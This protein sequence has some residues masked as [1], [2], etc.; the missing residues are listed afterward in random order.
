MALFIPVIFV[1]CALIWG[2]AG[3]LVRYAEE[4]EQAEHVERL[5]QGV[6]G[7]YWL[8]CA[9]IIFTVLVY[10]LL[11]RWSL[12]Y[13]LLPAFEVLLLL[14]GLLAGVYSRLVRQRGPLVA[15]AVVVGL[16]SPVL[17][18]WLVWYHPATFYHTYPF[19]IRTVPHEYVD[20]RWSWEDEAMG[21]PTTGL[22]RASWGFDYY[23]GDINL[24][25]HRPTDGDS[26]QTEVE[27]DPRFW[28]RVH[29]LTLSSDASEGQLDVIAQR[30]GKYN[31]PSGE[32][33][34]P[35]HQAIRFWI[36]RSPKQLKRPQVGVE[37]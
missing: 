11:K 31:A 13:D 6:R 26:M 12:S 27:M 15:H 1:Y 8:T 24:A 32:V 30:P 7:L 22:Y 25:V 21:Y 5:R 9:P 2:S 37:P 18:Y 28:Q 16:A 10:S 23:V 33:D 14:S 3:L 4:V 34:P 29:S 35:V 17:V 19:T 36:D 20:A